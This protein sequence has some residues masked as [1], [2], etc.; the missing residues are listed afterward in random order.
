VGTGLGLAICHRII[1]NLG[2]TIGVD[3]KVGHGTRFR[4]SLPPA[5]EDAERAP[6]PAPVLTAAPDTHRQI[7]VI[8]DEPMI[9]AILRR[10]LG[11]EHQVTSANSVR[12]GLQRIEQ[13]EHFDVILCDLMMPEM[14]GMD[15]HAELVAKH[16]ALS[17][18]VVFMTGGAFTPA[19]REFLDHV[20]NGR[21]EKPFEVHIL[22][23][24]IK[25]II[26][27]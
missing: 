10:M 6:T 5:K 7:L 8:D 22:K 24:L 17:R 12:E 20:P 4:V 11:R 15:L 9:N 14:T 13:G 2:G 1:T 21:I 26:S 18:R 3:S 19:A 27:G 23:S 16:P 25:G